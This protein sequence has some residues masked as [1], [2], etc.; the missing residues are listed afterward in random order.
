MVNVLAPALAKVLPHLVGTRPHAL[1][2]LPELFLGYTEFLRPITDLVVL[3]GIDA[4]TILGTADTRV[5]GHDV[6]LK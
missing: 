1:H 5:V 2:R 3:I 4:T 6:L